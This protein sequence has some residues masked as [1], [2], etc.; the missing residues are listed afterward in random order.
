MRVRITESLDIDLTTEMWCCNRC[1]AA[2]VSAR[3]NYKQGCLVFERDP[4]STYRPLV[5]GPYTFAPDP[6]WCRIIEF[7]CPQ[8]GVMFENEVLPPGYPPTHDIELNLERL[9]AK[10]GFRPGGG[11]AAQPGVPA[12]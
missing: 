4:R 3:S 10:H 11:P 12:T 8:C 2:L 7:Y 9:Q 6:D 5:E 1:G